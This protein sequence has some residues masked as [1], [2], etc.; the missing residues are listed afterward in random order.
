MLVRRSLVLSL[1]FQ[2]EFPHLEFVKSLTTIYCAGHHNGPMHTIIK[3]F[4][5][6]ISLT[7]CLFFNPMAKICNA[8]L[9]VQMPL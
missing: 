4:A 5:N 2:L 9:L 1:P 3:V 6:A 8:F 7:I